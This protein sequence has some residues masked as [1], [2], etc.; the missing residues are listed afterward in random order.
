[1]VGGGRRGVDRAGTASVNAIIDAITIDVRPALHAIEHQPS[2]GPIT[3]DSQLDTECQRSRQAASADLVRRSRGVV[4]DPAEGHLL[5]SRIEQRIGGC[6]IAV[7]R[8]ADRADDRYPAPMPMHANRRA[9][10]R[11]K[12][13]HRPA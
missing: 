5:P 8:L 1:M 12:L 13:A 7:A 10:R 11:P 9:R 6:R 3:S 4:N 2:Y